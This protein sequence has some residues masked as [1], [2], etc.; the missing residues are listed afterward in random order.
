MD[1]VQE[2]IQLFILGNILIL[3]VVG[4]SLTFLGTDFFVEYDWPI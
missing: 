3:E 2:R 1:R 4:P